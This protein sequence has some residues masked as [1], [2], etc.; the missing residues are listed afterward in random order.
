MRSKQLLYANEQD[1][2]IRSLI[3][4]LDLPNTPYLIRYN[5]DNN[6]YLINQVMSLVPSIRLYF[7]SS[8]IS[9]ISEPHKL[10]R[11]YLSIIKHLLKDIILSRARILSIV[12]LMGKGS[13]P[14]NI[15]S[16]LK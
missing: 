15:F 3:N 2:L 4:I 8:S 7:A 16:F 6:T 12:S 1:Q 13:A 5:M 10:D 14:H 11:P 9:G